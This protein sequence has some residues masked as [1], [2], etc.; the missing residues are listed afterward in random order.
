MVGPY[1]F[2]YAGFRPWQYQP[3]ARIRMAARHAARH[4][5]V[6]DSHPEGYETLADRHRVPGNAQCRGK[7]KHAPVPA[8][9]RHQQRRIVGHPEYDI[10]VHGVIPEPHTVVH[11]HTA[12]IAA[13]VRDAGLAV[14][15]V[16]GDVN[17]AA[18]THVSD[19]VNTA[20]HAGNNV[21]TIVGTAQADTFAI[22]GSRVGTLRGGA[23]D[24]LFAFADGAALAGSLDGQSGADT[25]N[26]STHTSARSV[27]LTGP[28]NTD[29]FSI[30]EQDLKLR[31]PG[32]FFGSLQHG[33]PPSGL[34]DPLADFKLL[35]AARSAA[36][37]V[38]SGDPNLKQPG[39]RAIQERIGDFILREKAITN[40]GN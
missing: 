1:H 35:A 5:C 28:G 12:Q 18:N 29:G 7:H 36:Y 30:A 10:A 20:S 17:L 16:T 40:A 32:D 3:V 4:R 23:G 26:L 19:G 21:E 13:Q 8:P 9:V 25:L 2:H 34:A 37:E 27:A 11:A 33:F 14:S 39:H 31:G 15:M 22:S 38:I 24:D 6:H